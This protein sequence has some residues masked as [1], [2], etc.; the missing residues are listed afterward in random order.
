VKQELRDRLA[1]L[2]LSPI[3]PLQSLDSRL[4]EFESIVAAAIV[5]ERDR[6]TPLIRAAEW[7]SSLD[8]RA[9]ELPN[10]LSEIEFALKALEQ[11][12]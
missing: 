6:Y 8:W 9:K 10:A 4:A 12:E 11:A 2:A 7:A 1:N 5:D 3:D